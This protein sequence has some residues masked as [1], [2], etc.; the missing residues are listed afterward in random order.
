MKLL[1]FNYDLTKT[2]KGGNIQATGVHNMNVFDKEY[3]EKEKKIIKFF[4]TILLSKLL[5]LN[6]EFS[7]H[8][9][10]GTTGEDVFKILHKK[11]SYSK[12]EKQEIIDNAIMLIKIKYGKT[13]IDFEKLE[14]EK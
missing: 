10:N 6:Y 3:K 5:L 11:I 7:N 1:L 14:F 4:H 13:L 9:Y 8:E 12:K 2:C